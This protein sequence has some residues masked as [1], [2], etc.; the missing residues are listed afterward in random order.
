[1]D[2]KPIIALIGDS[3]SGKTSLI[4]GALDRLGNKIRII[5]SIT[6]RPRRG[7]EDDLYYH[8][9]T[10]MR[11]AQLRQE[12]DLLQEAKYGGSYY[13]T[14]RSEVEYILRQSFGINALVQESVLDFRKAGFTVKVVFVAVSD[15]PEHLQHRGDA[16]RAQ[17]DRA[18][19][20]ALLRP[21]HLIM[22]SFAPGG[23]ERAVNELVQYIE[24]L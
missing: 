12:G 1:M 22:N 19:A 21:D 10:P 24:T 4:E 5:P 13:G 3:G 18:R 7:P 14:R 11:F 9:T 16:K 2:F 8:F 17:D 20:Q 6:T 15:Q 23:F